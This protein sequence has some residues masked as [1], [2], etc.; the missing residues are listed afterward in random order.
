VTS[1]L[2]PVIAIRSKPAILHYCIGETGDGQRSRARA[3]GEV[4]SHFK[5]DR[6][7]PV[8]FA[9]E[10]RVIQ[11]ALLAAVQLHPAGAVRFTILALPD[12]KKKPLVDERE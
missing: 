10:V 12:I 11:L 2:D 6:V 9:L 3:C 4:L 8:P 1:L 5:R 7:T